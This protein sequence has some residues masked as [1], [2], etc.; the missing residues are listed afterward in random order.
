VISKSS[1][2]LVVHSQLDWVNPSICTSFSGL[3][4]ATSDCTVHQI[5]SYELAQACPATRHNVSCN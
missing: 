2:S 5:V 4:F 1:H 3:R